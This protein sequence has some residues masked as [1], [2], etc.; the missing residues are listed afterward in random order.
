MGKNKVF[1]FDGFVQSINE[2]MYEEFDVLKCINGLSLFDRHGM[3]DYLNMQGRQDMVEYILNLDSMLYKHKIDILFSLSKE[4]NV[5]KINGL[6]IKLLTNP[7]TAIKIISGVDY[8]YPLHQNMDFNT[9]DF[10]VFDEF[11]K[12]DRELNNYEAQSCFS[13]LMLLSILDTYESEFKK[14]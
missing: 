4:L 3:I 12:C 10:T 13:V 1:R 9:L 11:W 7:D 2:S 6:K 14:M 8:K 5:E